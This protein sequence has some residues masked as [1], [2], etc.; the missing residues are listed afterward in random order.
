MYLKLVPK[1][2]L[3]YNMLIIK[4]ITENDCPFIVDLNAGKDADFLKQWAGGNVYTYP[5]TLEQIKNHI[6]EETSQI[7][8]IFDDEICVG[9]IELNKIDTKNRSA[10]V[11]RFI[12]TKNK[13]NNGLGTLV[14]KQL[15]N[16]AFK[17]MGL[18]KLTLNVFCFNVG[19][20]RCYEKAG[21]LVKEYK[22]Q[23]DTKWN[24]YTMELIKNKQNL[25]KT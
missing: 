10:N 22:Q 9:S 24:G 8:M 11:C 16:R 23:E 17:E 7:F 14:L 2:K 1:T 18:E 12:L 21:F 4:P 19:A 3:L 15:S 25:S 13:K 5:I 20:I 6:K